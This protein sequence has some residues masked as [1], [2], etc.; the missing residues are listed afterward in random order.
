MDY[1]IIDR[2]LYIPVAGLNRCQLTGTPARFFKAALA[3]AAAILWES[4]IQCVNADND[5]EIESNLENLL[6]ESWESKGIPP[7]PP[8]RNR[9]LLRVPLDFQLRGCNYTLGVA[10][11]Q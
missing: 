3:A 11:S 1:P 5:N 7:I 4:G 6:Q 2:A 9:A 8:Q 10:P